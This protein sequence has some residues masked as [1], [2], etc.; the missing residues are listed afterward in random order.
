M[1]STVATVKNSLLALPPGLHRRR[2]AAR[3]VGFDAWIWRGGD[4]PVLL[5]NGAT[6]GD[7]Y[8]GP[9]LLRA[10]AE[11]WRPKNLRGT[12]VTVPVLNEAA[13]F[14]GQRCHPADGGNLA[15]AFP[16]SAR[17][18][19][20]AR[21][22]HLFDTHLLAQATHYV[23]LHSAGAAYELLPWTGYITHPAPAT[24]RTQRAMAACFAEFWC[25]AGPFLPGRTLSAA[26]ARGIPAIYVE[27][28]GAGGVAPADLE[29]LD[30]G[31]RRVL[32]RLGLLAGPG[33][34]RP[35]AAQRFRLTR[36]ADEA[37]LQIHHPAPADGLFTP[38]VEVGDRIRRGQAVGQVAELG[39][40][41]VHRVGAERG[42]RVVMLRRQRSVRRGDALCT[43]APV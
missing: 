37:H 33:P 3:G 25:W 40:A 24:D 6:H 22:A 32:H 7:E 14:A 29:N 30:L 13:F 9:T 12:V 15:R 31:L 35:L 43:L 8:E 11:T 38:T 21:L 36:D 26:H 17:G 39:S 23:D 4:G 2:F 41:A 10:W 27:C 1:E 19:V 28:R 42:G 34:G 5:V 18:G 16:G 20:T